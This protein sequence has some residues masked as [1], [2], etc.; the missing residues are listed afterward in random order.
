LPTWPKRSHLAGL[1]DAAGV[2]VARL[3]GVLACRDRWLLV[4][5]NA[6]P[7]TSLP[8]FIPPGSGHVL[9]TSRNPHRAGTAVPVPVTV[10]DRPDSVTVLRRHR[11]DLTVPQ[12]ERIADA[13]GDLP[14][15]VDQAATL[16]A[17]TMLTADEY[18]RLLTAGTRDVLGRGAPEGTTA[19]KTANRQANNL[20][21]LRQAAAARTLHEDSLNRYRRIVGDGHPDTLTSVNNL[22]V[23]LCALGLPAAARTLDEDTLSRRRRILGKEHPDTLTTASNLAADLDALGES[24]NADR[25]R[26]WATDEQEGG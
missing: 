21:A 1:T 2:A 16:L 17:D 11:P 5:D 22:A 12:A 19:L 26:A 7:P 8:S 23:G 6:E 20:R 9:I 4:F 10:F 25:R 15:V 3:F 14:Q 24:A 18:L 13:L